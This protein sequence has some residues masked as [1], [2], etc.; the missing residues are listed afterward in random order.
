MRK[1]HKILVYSTSIFL[2]VIA[3]MLVILP[4]Y[5]P[6]NPVVI[7]N[8]NNGSIT[9]VKWYFTPNGA[10]PGDTIT[11]RGYIYNSMNNPV[12]LYVESGIAP[13]GWQH[14]SVYGTPV[15]AP[16]E[17]GPC[18]KQNTNYD[19]GYITI[20]PHQYVYVELHPKVPTSGTVDHCHN[21][22]SFYNG[23]NKQYDIAF[24]VVKPVNGNA[25]WHSD[26]DHGQTLYS[27]VS[28]I[29]VGSNGIKFM[30]TY[31]TMTQMIIISLMILG[32]LS[33]AVIILGDKK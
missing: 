11:V 7:Y 3:T 19:G 14:F 15:K 30:G 9:L 2:V 13:H 12:R 27:S 5:I 22:G 24:I 18:C 26:T 4:H 28:Q 6:D 16:I 10:N 31:L 17:G 23:V 21:L 20:Q 32:I 8:T 33:S 25:C 29:Y 1:E